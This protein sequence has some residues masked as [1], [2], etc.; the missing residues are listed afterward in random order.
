[1]IDIK[2]F[3]FNDDAPDKIA[4]YRRNENSIGENWPIVYII[5]NDEEAYVGET[6]NASVRASQ[7][8]LN[9]ERRKLTEIRILSDDTFN[10]SVIIDLESYLIK[11]IA[12]DGKYVLQNGN[13]GIQDHNYYNKAM[14]AGTFRDI[15]SKLKSQGVVQQSIEEIENSEL[16][17]YSP[18]KSLGREQM[19]AEME[20][21]EAL[22]KYKQYPGGSSIVVR[23]SAGTGKTILGVYLVKLFADINADSKNI[24]ET[25]EY[26]DGSSEFVFAAENIQ[27]IEKIG[28]VVPQESLKSTLKDVFS[29]VKN[30]EEKMVLTPYDVVKDYRDTGKKFDLLVVDEAHM[31]KCRWHGHLSNYGNFDGPCEWLGID[32]TI[33]SEL[34]W[35]LQCSENQIMFRDEL[36]TVRPCDLY[37]DEFTRTIEEKYRRPYIELAL[38]VQ[39]RCRGGNEYIDYIRNLISHI[40]QQKRLFQDYDVKLYNDCDEMIEAI[41]KKDS[42]FGLCR[43]VAGYAWPWKSKSDKTEYDIIIGSY[44]YRWNSTAKNWINSSNAINEIGCIHT[45]QGYDLNYA[46]VIIGEDIKYDKEAGTIIADKDC[47]FDKQGK[48][49]VANNHEALLEYLKNIYLTLMTR[50]IRGTYIYVCDDALREYFAEYFEVV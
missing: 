3:D 41:K 24:F 49:G 5:N 37:A 48:S 1:M 47:Y 36:Q 28:I 46:G 8:L 31:L 7:H 22:S 16:F 20:I 33:S 15:W 6:L 21:L 32:K 23:G 44:K 25:D 45:V 39:W 10:K 14:Y 42:E 26:I 11:H 18:Y 19:L 50:G 29:K 38:N 4:V 34:D 13:N 9:G 35:I 30:L 2:R 40:P 12:S 17:K 43:N 27:G